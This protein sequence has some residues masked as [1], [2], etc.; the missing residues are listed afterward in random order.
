MYN[1]HLDRVSHIA[2]KLLPRRSLMDLLTLRSQ[3]M[4]LLDYNAERNSHDE[5][6]IKQVV[7]VPAFL[8]QRIT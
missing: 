8:D 5:V 2:V 4:K 7:E 6:Q 3:Y 1:L